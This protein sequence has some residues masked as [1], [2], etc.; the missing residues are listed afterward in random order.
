MNN[1]LPRALGFTDQGLEKGNPGKTWQPHKA[2]PT[3]DK[4]IPFGLDAAMTKL[5]GRGA[6]F[7]SGDPA[8]VADP[9]YM[10]SSPL[11]KMQEDSSLLRTNQQ[12]ERPL[13]VLS[14]RSRESSLMSASPKCEELA[15]SRRRTQ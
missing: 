12:R 1:L 4:N 6:R 7:L 9:K 11:R 15:A 5:D 14:T 2:V 13:C 10:F 8:P 3:N